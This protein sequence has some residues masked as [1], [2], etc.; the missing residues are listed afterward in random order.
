MIG[1]IAAWTAAFFI[2]SLF[3]CGVHPQIQWTYKDSS[4]K[5]EQCAKSPMILLL[6]AIT[7]V[8][9]DL[10]ILALPFGPVKALQK[11]TR[12]KIAVIGIFM[13]GGL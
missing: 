5:T 12:E 6:F 7:D 11:S 4:E 1:I 3:V 13:L 9:G 10:A 2:T 8:M